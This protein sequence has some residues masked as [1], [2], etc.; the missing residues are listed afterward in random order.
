[1]KFSKGYAEKQNTKIKATN[2]GDEYKKK[3]LKVAF[4]KYT[5][6]E[7]MEK[8]DIKYNEF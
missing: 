7:L 3:V 6:E 2:L 1:M 8:L 4:N 5:L